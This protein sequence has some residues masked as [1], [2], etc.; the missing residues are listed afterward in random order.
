[1]IETFERRARRREERGAFS[2]NAATAVAG[3]GAFAYASAAAAQTTVTDADVLNFALNL[4]YLEANF[5]ALAVTGQP[6]PL[7]T[8]AA[9]RTVRPSPAVRCRA[10]ARWTNRGG[11]TA[12]EQYAREIYQDELAHGAIPAQQRRA[13]QRRGRRAARHHDLRGGGAGTPFGNAAIAAQLGSSSIPTIRPTN[14]SLEAY[15]FEDVGVTAYKGAAPLITNP[16]FLEATGRHPG[17]RGV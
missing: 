9:R 11:D 2:V 16:T 13:R 8:S 10:A 15:I 4:E 6:L 17:G 5:Y 3:A 12:V 1:M 7:P 14:S